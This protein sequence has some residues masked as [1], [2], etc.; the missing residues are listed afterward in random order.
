MSIVYGKVLI[1]IAA[2]STPCRRL[3]RVVGRA[4][5]IHP[6]E[7]GLWVYAAAWEFEVSQHHVQL[8]AAQ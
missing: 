6:T 8:V 5:Q 1:W 2:A 3:G 4:L 7:P